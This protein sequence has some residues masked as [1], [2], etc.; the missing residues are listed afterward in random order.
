[1]KVTVTCCS[2]FTQ[3]TMNFISPVYSA[4]QNYNASRAHT[5][6]YDVARSSVD[7]L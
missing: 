6:V 4:R 5:F 3:S 7:G 2:D 1:V